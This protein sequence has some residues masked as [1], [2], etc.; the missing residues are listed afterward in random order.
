MR[1]THSSN[2]EIVNCNYLKKNKIYSNFVWKYY[3]VESA[4]I[5]SDLFTDWNWI[6]SKKFK[7]HFT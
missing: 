7:L 2:N 6:S 3:A 5:F 4:G 1:P